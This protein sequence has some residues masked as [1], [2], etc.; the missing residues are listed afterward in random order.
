MIVDDDKVEYPLCRTK[1]GW[2]WCSRKCRE[3]DIK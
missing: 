1:T 2:N 3:T